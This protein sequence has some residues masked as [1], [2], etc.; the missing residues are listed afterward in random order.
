MLAEGTVLGGTYRLI[1]EIGAGGGGVVYKAYHEN[2]RK[3]VVVKQIRDVAKGVINS[4]G[5]ADI[6]KNLRNSYLP[7]VYD[8][9]TEGN[10]IYTVIDYIEGESLGNA[11]EREGHFS[12]KYVLKWARQLA[13]ALDY[14]HRQN[15]PIIHS[16]IKPDNIMLTPAG[17]IC[18]ID[19]NISLAF[20]RT[21]RLSAGISKGYSPPEQY[22]TPEMYRSFIVDSSSQST[23]QAFGYS[24]NRITEKLIGRGIDERSDIYSLGATLY[25]LLTGI[26]PSTD[27]GQI[28]PLEEYQGIASS[29]MVRII[30]KMMQLQP[31]DRFKNGTELKKALDNIKKYDSTQRSYRAFC[32]VS[33]TALLL[34]Y[35]A[36]AGLIAGGLN[37]RNRERSNA[38][39]QELETASQ[40]MESGEF[41]SAESHISA[42][43]ESIPT[44][45][46]AYAKQV[47]LLYDR[48]DYEGCTS[49][50]RD[51]VNSPEY[52]VQTDSDRKNLGDILYV[53]GN[54]YFEMKAF[55]DAVNCLE[56]AI[57]YNT[58]NS[59]YYRDL[60]IALARAGDT[61]KAEDVLSQAETYGLAE[62]SISML[63]GEIALAEA[64][65]EEA[66]GHFEKALNLLQDGNLR[67]RCVLLCAEAY[68]RLGE[69]YREKE[70]AFLEKWNGIFGMSGSL[71]L[72]EKLAELYASTGDY[73][74]ALDLFMEIKDS[75][76]ASYRLMENI[77]ILQ[78]EMAQTDAA[79]A[80]LQEM[81][82]MYPDRYEAYK[83]L[84]FL[85]ADRQQHLPNESRN[86]AAMKEYYDKACSLYDSQKSFDGEMQQMQQMMD[87]LEAGGWFEQ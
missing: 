5:E 85:E 55:A 51:T 86:Y 52:Y 60:G 34:T 61:G 18:L 84:A 6:L 65:A 17:D 26:A 78:Q 66:V 27:F 54:S 25:H 67:V 57:N 9:L 50:G 75:G 64:H 63:R 15:P 70:I 82:Q 37:L 45:I 40:L 73:A 4:R 28:V 33:T 16:D 77:A 62:E 8:F 81:V 74:K 11:L 53:M 68:D 12:Q 21:K 24:G 41:D 49:Y 20:D 43:M 83:R 36:G 87:E 31:E 56:L 14:L 30:E 47:L 13:D 44:R 79:E 48:G 80:S 29:G 1:E 69:T 19:F 10:E 76:F 23:E 71:Q 59:A 35:I 3:Y 2:L 42:A 72:D 39:Y 58:G 32:A 38:Y 22:H 7:Q 46:D